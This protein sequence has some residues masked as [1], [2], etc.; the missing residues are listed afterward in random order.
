[1][2]Y[3]AYDPGYDAAKVL[4]YDFDYEL[5]LLTGNDLFYGS[6]DSPEGDGL[7]GL[8]GNDKFTGYGD[9]QYGD[10]FDGGEGVDTSVYR[11]KRADY[12]VKFSDD[13]WDSIKD[14]GSRISG[15]VV[16]DKGSS[17]D[18][19]DNLIGVERLKFSDMTLALDVGKGQ[20]A[21]AIYRLY[22]AAFDRAPKPAGEGYWL[23][24]LDGGESLQQIA[25][26]FIQTDEFHRI[27]GD[28]PTPVDY[29]YKLFNNILGR[30]PKQGGLNYWLDKL[31]KTSMAD[32]LAGISES[33]ENIHN[34]EALI[35]NGIP[36]QEVA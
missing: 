21:G 13:I 26:Q 9:D 12:E 35:A 14:D 33:D 19:F 6:P 29:I 1:M 27:Y 8:A 31:D 3:E 16:T 11:G 18:G 30:D 32:V 23:K 10:Y 7:Q 17:G 20:N 28:N 24:K 22:E 25:A 2:S 34:A 4:Y 15:Y 36:Y 5:S